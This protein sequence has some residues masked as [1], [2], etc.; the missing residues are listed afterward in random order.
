MCDEIV[1]Q[2][3]ED[4]DLPEAAVFL[5]RFSSV[6]DVSSVSVWLSKSMEDVE[7]AAPA[8]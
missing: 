8:W 7:D 6:I 4:W 1:D 3:K 5:R 2:G